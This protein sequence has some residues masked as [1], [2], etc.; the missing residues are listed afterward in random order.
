MSGTATYDDRLAPALADARQVPV[1]ADQPFSA[2]L[3]ALAGAKV[4]FFDAAI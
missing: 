4:S 2:S 1:V 3:T